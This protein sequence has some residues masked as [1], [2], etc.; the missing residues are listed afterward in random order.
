MTV[1]RQNSQGHK[2]HL[3][4]SKLRAIENRRSLVRSANTGVSAIINQKGDIL[5]HL[6]YRQKRRN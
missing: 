3:M 1:G 4:L 5:K 2:Q 6:D